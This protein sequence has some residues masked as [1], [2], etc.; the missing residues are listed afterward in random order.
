M[1]SSRRIARLA[2]PCVLVLAASCSQL[3]A[4]NSTPPQPLQWRL[5]ETLAQVEREALAT[6]F[7]VADRLLA[8][9]ATQHAGTHESAEAHF[10]RAVFKLDRANPAASPRE[11]AGLLDEYL[12]APATAQHRGSA[13]ALRRVAGALDPSNAG[14]AATPST[15]GSTTSTPSTPGTTTSPGAAP[16]TEARPEA[17]ADERRDEEIQRLREELAKANAE[18]ERIRK[19]MAQPNP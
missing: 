15:P 12:S 13:T 4:A 10:W 8:D 17:R 2:A 18:L 6:R 1:I 14:L 19:R 5:E 16:R 7:D 9:F 3:R 11:A